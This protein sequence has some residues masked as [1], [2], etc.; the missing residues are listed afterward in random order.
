MELQQQVAEILTYIK[1]IAPKI[2]ECL[3]KVDACIVKVSECLVR[4]SAC[5]A[6]VDECLVRVQA[7]EAKVDECL[8]RV[9]A[10]EDLIKTERSLNDVRHLQVTHSIKELDTKLSARIDSL[11]ER[12]DALSRS[13]TEDICAIAMDQAKL[14]RRVNIIEHKLE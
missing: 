9:Q 7:C 6:K 2:D 14:A 12:V 1:A 4:I 5:E 10:C 8:V 13:V 3:V 11:G